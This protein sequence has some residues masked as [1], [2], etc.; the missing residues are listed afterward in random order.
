MN[1]LITQP[2]THSPMHSLSLRHTHTHTHTHTQFLVIKSEKSEMRSSQPLRHLSSYSEFTAEA[3][4]CL[5]V[6]PTKC[7]HLKKTRRGQEVWK[8]SRDTSKWNLWILSLVCCWS[9]SVHIVHKITPRVGVTESKQGSAVTAW[10]RAEML[11][12]P[13]PLSQSVCF[14]T[15]TMSVLVVSA[16]IVINTPHTLHSCNNCTWSSGRLN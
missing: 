7:E 16:W 11:H 12:T 2:S 8:S 15:E 6:L 5:G 9:S 10:A 1:Q 14:T 4:Y 3:P 13:A